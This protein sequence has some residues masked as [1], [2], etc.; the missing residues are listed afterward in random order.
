MS[1]L[2]PHFNITIL[3]H[4]CRA[5]T[6]FLI[7]DL[8]LYNLPFLLRKKYCSKKEILQGMRFKEALYAANLPMP[9]WKFGFQRGVTLQYRPHCEPGAPNER[10]LPAVHTSQ[11]EFAFSSY[12]TICALHSMYWLDYSILRVA[13]AT[14]QCIL[15][16]LNLLSVH[17]ITSLHFIM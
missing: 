15:H 14:Q 10:K 1:G 16:N 9:N 11:S 6:E 5:A 4:H 3:N 17:F 8:K 12:F 2:N 13:R 7:G